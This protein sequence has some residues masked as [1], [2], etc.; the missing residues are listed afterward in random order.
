MESMQTTF[1]KHDAVTTQS[2]GP[3]G[4]RTLEKDSHDASQQKSHGKDTSDKT[5]V[6]N[7][8]VNIRTIILDVA[9]HY[10]HQSQIIRS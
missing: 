9:F 10:T 7:R 8:K 3:S 4:F 5:S 2:I 6:T 1:Q